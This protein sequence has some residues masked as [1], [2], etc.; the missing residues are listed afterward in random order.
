MRRKT[1]PLGVA[2]R[3]KL[4]LLTATPLYCVLAFVP[5][6]ADTMKITSEPSG[7]TVEIDGVFVGKTPYEAKFPGG[8]FHQ[9]RSVFG[10][11]LRTG[12]RARISLDGYVTQDI[13]LTRGP[14]P[15][16]AL[17]GVHHGDYYLLKTDHFHF[18][19]HKV[20][21]KFTGTVQLASS[22][23]GPIS[24][25][26][27]LPPERIVEIAAPAVV[28]LKSPDGWGTGFFITDTGVL[29]TNAHVASGARTMVV[30]DP[31]GNQSEATVL[32]VSDDLDFALLKVEGRNLPHLTLASIDSVRQGQPVLAIGNPAGGMPNTVTKG[33]VSA[34]GPYQDLKGTW[35]QTDAA[36]NPG[37]SGGP[38]LN[39]QGEVIGINTLR[40]GKQETQGMGFA[41]SSEDLMTILVRFYPNEASP[42]QVKTTGPAD[43]GTGKIGV[44]SVPP[45]AE[46]Y[47]DDM[48]VGTTPTTVTLPAGPHKIRVAAKGFKEWERK[49]QMLKGNEAH[50]KATLEPL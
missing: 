37:N 23:A 31:A 9:T 12:M 2:M 17:N 13:V 19:L 16:V 42:P 30:Q 48:L 18:E 28:R 43:E 44:E 36:I 21:G 5:A 46:I 41:L 50:L 10:K 4:V 47:V 15:W 39:S 6:L 11:M 22:G 27:E 35:I 24:M 40:P 49:V 8:Y 38:L 34:V 33:I 25:L 20:A 32:Y 14:M 7:A 1:V 29:A 3:M 26:P 45:D